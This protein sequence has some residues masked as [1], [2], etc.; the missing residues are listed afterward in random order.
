MSNNRKS[1]SR[2]KK[3]VHKFIYNILANWSRMDQN[4]LT[5]T[6]KH[7]LLKPSIHKQNLPDKRRNNNVHKKSLL[8]LV[9]PLDCGETAAENYRNLPRVRRTAAILQLRG[10]KGLCR[11]IH[12]SSG[13]MLGQ[14]STVKSRLDFLEKR[15][16]QRFLISFTF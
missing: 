14:C 15:K 1:Y 12:P 7:L 3:N 6:S 10:R 16:E 2:R 11:Y 8:T 13:V 9:Y 5:E 4:I